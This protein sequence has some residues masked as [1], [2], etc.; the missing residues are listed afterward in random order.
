[1]NVRE[2]LQTEDVAFEV[3]PHRS[4]FTA[5][6]LAHSLDVPGDNVAKTVL[7]SVDDDFV[8][9]VLPATH[10]IS[11]SMLKDCLGA[12]S[13]ELATEE[14]LVTVFPDCER[15]VA[16]PF[17]TQYNLTTIV[18]RSLIED[19]NIVFESNSHSEAISLRYD[20]YAKIEKPRVEAFT[21]HV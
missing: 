11:L 13:V 6:H 15:G 5:Q 21:T 16:P 2:F 8:L 20:D 17:G 9:A 1:M 18:D 12:G 7:V 10:Q 14:Q 4:T 3:L 19:E